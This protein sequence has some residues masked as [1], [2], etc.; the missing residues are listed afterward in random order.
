MIEGQVE[1]AGQALEVVARGQLGDD[2]AEVPVQVDLG[3]DDVGQDLAAVLHDRDGGFVAGGFDA[4]RKQ[5]LLPRPSP[6]PSPP[7]GRGKL[8]AGEGYSLVR[9]SRRRPRTSASM[10]S[11]LDS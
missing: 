2:A 6:W 11:R 9:R 5:I 3:V 4:Q 10:R 7:K 8:R 1:E